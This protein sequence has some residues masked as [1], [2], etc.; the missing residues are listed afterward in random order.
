MEI[1]E[2]SVEICERLHERDGDHE[3]EGHE[4]EEDANEH[5]PGIELHVGDGNI[6]P[7]HVPG[8]GSPLSEPTRGVLALLRLRTNGRS[9]TRVERHEPRLHHILVTTRQQVH[10]LL[11]DL[12]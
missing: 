5:A 6:V 8:F 1:L 12:R 4:E 2:Q 9:P 3:E 10:A 11:F 7:A